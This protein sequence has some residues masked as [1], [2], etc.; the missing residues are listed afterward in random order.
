MSREL[1]PTEMAQAVTYLESVAAY[2]QRPTV[3]IRLVAPTEAELHQA[4]RMLLQAH[5]GPL[6]FGTPRRGR[7]GDW[8]VYGT[9]RCTGAT[10]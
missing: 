8:I 4:M 9:L 10:A 2:L 5:P 3:Q 1:T 6:D 7:K